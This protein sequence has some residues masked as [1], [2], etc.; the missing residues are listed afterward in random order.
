MVSK[1]DF[2][3]SVD[4]INKSTSILI[5]THTRPDGDACASIV[6]LRDALTTLGKSVSLIFLTEIPEWYESLFAEKVPILG[7]DVTVE[8]LKAGQ[9]ARPDLIM[10]IDTNSYQ[11]APRL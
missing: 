1:D 2:Q 10:I 9:F 7:Q 11:P 5:T 3:K 4:L 8:Q 6:A